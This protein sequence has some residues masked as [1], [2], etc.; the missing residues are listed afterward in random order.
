MS[1]LWLVLANGLWIL[2]L[3]VILAALSWASWVAHEQKRTFIRVLGQAD[4]Q[5][6]LCGGLALFC[7]GLAATG[8]RPWMQVIWGLL[9]AVWLGLFVWTFWR[10]VDGNEEDL[11]LAT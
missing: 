9:A 4:S 5:R 10:K 11:N 7:A 8:Y 1:G 3:A 6:A 2:G